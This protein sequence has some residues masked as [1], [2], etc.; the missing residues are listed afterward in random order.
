MFNN[1]NG[2][3]AHG[4]NR[5]ELTQ[6]NAEDG[7]GYDFIAGIV[8]E[9]DGKTRSR[10]APLHWAFKSWRTMDSNAGHRPGGARHVAARQNLSDVKDIAERF[11]TDDAVLSL[12]P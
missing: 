3:I 7:G 6:F 1:P 2:C 11:I 9:L 5:H 10:G 8:L 4:P 12:N